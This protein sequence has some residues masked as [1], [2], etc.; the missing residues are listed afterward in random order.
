VDFDI[1]FT[2]MDDTPL[3]KKPWFYIAAWL[4]IVLVVYGWQI[5]RMG[6]FVASELE[7]FIDLACVFP[8]LL[9]IWMAFFAQFVLPV[10]TFPDRQKIFDRLITYMFGGH[11]PAMFIR[12]GILVKR[13]G[14][15][16]KKGPG[17]L[18]LDSASAA[19]TRTATAIKQ[20]MG[21]GVHFINSGEY[22]AGTV[23]LHVQNQGVGPKESDKPFEKK[24]DE[25]SEDEFNQIQDRR[26]QV[27]ALTRDGIEVVPNISVTFRVDTGFPKEGQPGSRFG[28]RTGITKR[29]KENEKQDQEAVRK[30]IL[31]EGI[32][33]NIR[34]DSPR[35]R[36]AWNQLPAVL[37]VDLWREYAAKFTLDELFKPEQLVPPAPP[38][39]AQTVEEEFD[40]LSQPLQVSANRETMQDALTSILRFINLR[41][42]WMIKWLEG[43]EIDKPKKPLTPQTSQTSTLTP[44]PAATKTE[45]QKKT[46][47]QVINEMVKARLT[48][49]EV[50]ILDDT[51]R[52]G[53]G[54][55]PSK[56]YELL[57]DRGLKLISVSISSPRFSPTVEDSIIK[58]WNASWL[59]NAKAESEQI[60][61]QRNNKEKE[62]EEKA[63]RQYIETVSREI[64]ELSRHGKPDIKDTLKALILKSHTIIRTNEQLRRRMTTELQ[65]IEEMIKWIEGNGK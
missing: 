50:D 48:Q 41:M 64:N 49:A 6:G 33:P 60:D 57:R 14:E 52:R 38:Q 18:W 22:I 3:Y 8:I 36:V 43:K 34:A 45:P 1:Q 26:K 5:F 30:A 19:V 31:G 62:A 51:G 10:R 42:D 63:K 54:T 55:I 65:D 13:E 47:L 29:D 24:K 11:G 61:R 58:G 20:T 27:S 40:P 15:E 25:Q 9:V 56:E 39:P 44:A 46:G 59:N 21:P 53:E 28:F 32:N 23:D 2:S 37:A 12:D 7:I 35:H 17:V 4:F 16:R